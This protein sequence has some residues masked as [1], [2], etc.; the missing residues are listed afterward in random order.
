[1]LFDFQVPNT[2]TLFISRE[3]L[4]RLGGFD[5]SLATCEDHDLWIRASH[6]GAKFFYEKNAIS[7]FNQHNESRL[8]LEIYKRFSSIKRLI[9][10]RRKEGL[11]PFSL[12]LFA[13]NYA[14][15]LFSNL[16]IQSV[17]L[18]RPI[19]FL[20]II[21]ELFYYPLSIFIIF[22]ILYKKVFK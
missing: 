6:S 15:I 16:I 12:Y 18:K 11:D 2:S 4:K 1:M 5:E 20:Q 9:E 19:I 17:K 3:L 21:K 22:K 10:N 13:N 7:Y 14:A 8:S